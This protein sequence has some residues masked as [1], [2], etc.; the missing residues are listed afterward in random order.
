MTFRFFGISLLPGT[1]PLLRATTEDF[2]ALISEQTWLARL[3]AKDFE[4]GLVFLPAA[5]P[6]QVNVV[7]DLFSPKKPRTALLVLLET[8]EE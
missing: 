3:I 2:S 8:S 6:T 1:F 5:Y 4:P 7:A